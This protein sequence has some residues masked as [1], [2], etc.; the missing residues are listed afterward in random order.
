MC[1]IGNI[2]WIGCGSSN[3]WGCHSSSRYSRF[4]FVRYFQRGQ[5]ICPSL[6]SVANGQQYGWTIRLQIFLG[7]LLKA[8]KVQNGNVVGRSKGPIPIPIPIQSWEWSKHLSEC[9]VISTKTWDPWLGIQTA[10]SWYYQIY[11]LFIKWIYVDIHN[12]HFVDDASVAN[13]H[14]TKLA[15]GWKKTAQACSCL[16]T[17]AAFCISAWC[18]MSTYLY[19]VVFFTGPP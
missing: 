10:P 14:R 11:T 6:P 13:M 17:H 16:V 3:I 1:L 8:P 5:N 7:T 2:L 19:R 15:Q 12:M 18:Q 4:I 9:I